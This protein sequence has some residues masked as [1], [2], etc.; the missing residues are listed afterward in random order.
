MEVS[1]TNKVPVVRMLNERTF[2]HG[3]LND[4]ET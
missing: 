1:S 2:R 3:K 4:Y